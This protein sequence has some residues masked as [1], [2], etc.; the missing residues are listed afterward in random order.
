VKARAPRALRFII[1]GFVELDVVLAPLNAGEICH[2]FRKPWDNNE[3][4]SV[5]RE[6]LAARDA[7][8]GCCGA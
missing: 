2:A 6:R 8:S 7:G 5:L 3:L 4:A 1:S